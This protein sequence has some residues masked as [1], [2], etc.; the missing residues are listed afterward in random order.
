[1]CSSD[2]DALSLGAT[3]DRL[4]MVA[5]EGRLDEFA[6]LFLPENLETLKT[7]FKLDITRFY[8]D[9]MG[10]SF[11]KAYA[12]FKRNSIGEEPL[13][14]DEYYVSKA[15]DAMHLL[16]QKLYV[17]Y[18]VDERTKADVEKM[19][20]GAI[21]TFLKRMD[22]YT[23]M[24]ESTREEAKKKLLNLRVIAVSPDDMS[25]PWDDVTATSDNAYLIYRDYLKA[26]V[27]FDGGQYG[28]NV[29]KDISIMTTM[30]TYDAN[31]MY[32]PSYSL[33]YFPAGLLTAPYYDPDA[34]LE[35][36]LGA[37]GAVM[38][39]EISH[40]FDNNGANYDGDGLVRNWW[41]E[42]DYTEFGKRVD[43]IIEHFDGYEAVPGY[44]NNP[45]LTVS[46]NIADIAGLSV[47]LEYLKDTEENPDLDKFF[48]SFASAWSNARVR[49][50]AI[51]LASDDVHSAYWLRVNKV[52]QVF[53]EFYEVYGIKEGDE[54]YLS[55][56]DRVSIW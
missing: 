54:M 9:Y 56:E 45:E 55:P 44:Y 27:K 22:T 12:A 49:Q 30:K 48:R 6:K 43:S 5:D 46:E 33:I 31:A 7:F 25:S 51:I 17:K 47:V 39:H 37:I 16:M 21:D 28:E 23:W 20:Q 32:I 35:E 52:V 38:G 8:R 26:L 1:V 41:T 2:L 42:K 15:R 19:A 36:N 24:N 13:P 34:T 40:A 18:Y 50:R 10:D 29:N 53:D 3:D 11:R 4:I 14:K